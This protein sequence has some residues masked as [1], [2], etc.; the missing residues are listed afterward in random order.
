MRGASRTRRRRFRRRRP[1]GR[2]G[3]GCRRAGLTAPSDGGSHGGCAGGLGKARVGR[4]EREVGVAEE[5]GKA[6]VR[7]VGLHMQHMRSS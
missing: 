2:G 4:V 3:G 6:R 7:Q 5:R 1:L